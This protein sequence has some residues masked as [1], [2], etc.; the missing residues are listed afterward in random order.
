MNSEEARAERLARIRANRG[1]PERQAAVEAIRQA[2]AP[3]A[4]QRPAGEEQEG[5]AHQLRTGDWV[6][7]VGGKH[8]GVQ[9]KRFR[10]EDTVVVAGQTPGQRTR[11]HVVF[12]RCGRW[13]LHTWTPVRF[14]RPTTNEEA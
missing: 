11:G 14:I 5:F 3:R 9:Y 2:Q 10:F 12:E 8:A 7:T 6:T 1:T 13:Q 4:T